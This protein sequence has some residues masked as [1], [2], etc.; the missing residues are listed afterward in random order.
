MH[1]CSSLEILSMNVAFGIWDLRAHYSHGK[2]KI[3][4]GKTTWE[5]LDRSLAN[6]EWLIRFGDSIVHH[7][8]C[9]TSDHSPILILPEIL[10]PAN[11]EKPF[12]FEEMWVG[13]KG[14]TKTIKAE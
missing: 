6:N 10:D 2:K 7:L 11:L 12:C 4:N 1:K 3:S 5:R 13:N 14:C 8:N 9:S